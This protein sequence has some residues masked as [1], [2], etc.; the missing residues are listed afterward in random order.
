MNIDAMKVIDKLTQ[1]M[2]LMEKENAIMSVQIEALMEELESLKQ[3][4]GE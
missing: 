4:Q 3:E 1:R 2:A